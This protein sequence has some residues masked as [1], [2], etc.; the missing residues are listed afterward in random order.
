M[1][2]LRASAP[3]SRLS[4][5]TSL[6]TGGAVWLLL[7]LLTACGNT[8]TPPATTSPATVPVPGT[9]QL[10]SV[11]GVVVLPGAGVRSLTHAAAH[12]PGEAIPGQYLVQ[13]RP[14]L[15]TQS[16]R[17]DGLEGA[18]LSTLS[19]D[20]VQLRRVKGSAE[21]GTWLYQA[22]AALS[23]VASGR[24]LGR[25]QALPEVLGA[26]PN[27][28]MAAYRTP[29]DLLYPLQWNAQAMNLPK[30]W[31]VTTGRAV[32]VAVVDTGIVAHPD[33]AGQTL[34]GMDFISDVTEAGDGDGV[35]SDPT[36][37][38]GDSD[39]HGTHVAGII[40]AKSN[41]ALGVAGLS[42][43]AKIVPVRVLG[44]TGGGSSADILLGTYW[45]AGGHVEGVK[46]NAN[47][48]RIIN[49]SLGGPGS[50][51]A[52]FQ[53]L[54]DTLAAQKV[55]VVVAAGNDGVDVSQ[56]TPANCANVI[57]V[58]ATG[59]DGKRAPYSNFGPRIDV[60]APGGNPGQN[61]TVGGTTYPG[62]ILSTVYDDRNKAYS[63][64]FYSGTSMAAPHVAGA[65]AL[66]LG[67]QPDLSFAEVRDRLK[68]SAT[69][70]GT[71]CDMPG[72]CGA[73]LVNVATLVSN[74]AGAPVTVPVSPAPV[75]VSTLPIKV[76]ALY[77]RPDGSYDAS[78]SQGAVIK[79]NT[80]RPSYRIGGLKAGTYTL[81]AWQD[82]NGNAAVDRGEPFGISSDLNVSQ[83]TP[84]LVDISV[85]MSAFS[86]QALPT[87]GVATM[88][89]LLTAVQE[90]TP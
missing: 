31:D 89:A 70:L 63:Y 18:A 50:C 60:M 40:A 21:L 42:W 67:E 75:T 76:V 28:W 32:A 12:R 36:D 22:D 37:L 52:G 11:S 8:T 46:D 56:S 49:L 88:S 57:A 53:K 24:L 68:A 81:A 23:A 69:S 59:P 54:F 61:I 19:V 15:G 77:T 38:G 7:G 78:L 35:D 65:V 62:G 6:W 27:V 13:L 66:L 44:V 34:P 73:G 9:P 39:Y 83:S 90:F 58:G 16:L 17:A 64:A 74:T 29:D 30:G 20:G 4:T 2:I 48:A 72:G 86:G 1:K 43:G 85:F 26:E 33:L 3:R 41:N 71:N 14:R 84:D 25:M 5:G 51:T 47:P 10:S 45:A 80:L 79:A 55:T 82:L 87:A